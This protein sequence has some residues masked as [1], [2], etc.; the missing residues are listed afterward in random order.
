M[1]KIITRDYA[2]KK[3]NTI[4]DNV[5]NGG[6]DVY[7]VTSANIFSLSKALKYINQVDPNTVL[8]QH[9]PTHHVACVY[10]KQ[11][12]GFAYNRDY[13]DLIAN[14]ID[15]EEKFREAWRQKNG[16]SPQGHFPAIEKSATKSQRVKHESYIVADLN[17]ENPNSKIPGSLSPNH[18]D[19]THLISS[20]ITGIERH[21][22]LLI[23]F[24]SWL[25]RTPM[26]KFETYILRMSNNQDIIWLAFVWQESD[27]LHWKYTMLDN[28]GT[29]LSERQWV[30]DR[31]TYIWKY[32]PYQENID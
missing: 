24:D 7:E 28:Q 32:D 29:I 1:F 27:G 26:N 13:L 22:G 18:V 12:T 21:K 6:T 17:S 25:N 10:V 19:R 31:W 20:Q 23:D 4:L 2:I 11:N 16:K 8:W 15:S 14:G 30:D 3:F 5:N 9:T